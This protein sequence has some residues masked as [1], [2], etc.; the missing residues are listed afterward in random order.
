MKKTL[1]YYQAAGFIFVGIAGVLLHFLFDWTG[2][3]VIA[4]LFAPVNESVWEHLKLIFFPMLIFALA[5]SRY[6]GK[7]YDNFWCV[8]FAGMVIGI[9][10]I[11]ILY[12]TIGGVLGTVPDWV[13]IL[14]FFLADAFVFWLET[15]L[16]ESSSFNCKLQTTAFVVLLLIA[17]IFVLMTFMPPHIPLFED[18]I[19]GTYGY[20]KSN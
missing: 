19:T 1:Y 16:F 7:E 12:Y 3:S 11:P 9:L 8:K 6:I 4:A 2:Q 18:P 17:V 5:E 14:I 20:M 15:K 10:I 13:N